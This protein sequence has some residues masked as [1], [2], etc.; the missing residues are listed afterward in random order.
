VRCRP[1]HLR[2]QLLLEHLGQ[3]RPE[4]ARLQLNLAVELQVEKHASFAA[5]SG[6]AAPA[7][8]RFARFAAGHARLV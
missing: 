7:H 1:A 2:P 6:P 4:E 3:A 8:S 5:S